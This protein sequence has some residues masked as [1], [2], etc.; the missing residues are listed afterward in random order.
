MMRN[1]FGRVLVAL[2]LCFIPLGA[3]TAQQLSY[4]AYEKVF[5]SSGS[6]TLPSSCTT[7]TV[8][9]IGGGAS[10][11]GGAIIT[12]GSSGSGGGSGG[13]GTL[14]TWRNLPI[15]Q[16]GSLSYTVAI[17][18]GGAQAAAGAAGNPGGNTTISFSSTSL[19][20][21]GANSSPPTAGSSGAAS[22]GGQGGYFPTIAPPGI[23]SVVTAFGA[24]SSGFGSS[25]T[26]TPSGTFV[27]FDGPTG[28]GAGGGLNAGT[29]QAGAPGALTFFG[30]SFI[31]ANGGSSEGASGQNGTNQPSWPVSENGN[32]GGGGAGNDNGVGGSGGAGGQPGGG[33]GGGGSGTGGGGS[34]GAGGAGAALV[35]CQ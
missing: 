12:A 24:A 11:A 8:K 21:P 6:G 4:H 26:G 19:E 10:G 14:Y 35:E 31:T 13:S 27:Y 1:F 29:F 17:G 25:A 15:P 3:A 22:S 32:G 5:F 30:A 9:A 34:G 2:S 20:A 18:A 28:G 33:G 16:L 23:G 7:L